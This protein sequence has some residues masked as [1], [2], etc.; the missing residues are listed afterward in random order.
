MTASASAVLK[1]Q[2]FP[3][4]LTTHIACSWFINDIATFVKVSTSDVR[5]YGTLLQDAVYENKQN[6]VRILLESG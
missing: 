6:F 2:Y 1:S 3:S 5:D 4:D